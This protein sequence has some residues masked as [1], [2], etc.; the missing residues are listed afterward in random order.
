MEIKAA[1][2][3]VLY[4]LVLD[5]DGNLLEKPRKVRT[6]EDVKGLKE[7]HGTR[8]LSVQAKAKAILAANSA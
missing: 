1:P 3:G 6:N 5:D 8:D 4:A 7:T 2:R